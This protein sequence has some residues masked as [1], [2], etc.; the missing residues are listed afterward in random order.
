MRVIIAVKSFRNA[1]LRLSHILDS[2]QRYELSKLMLTDMLKVLKDSETVSAVTL[3]SSEPATEALCRE[4]GIEL[5]QTNED[6]GYSEDATQ[7]IAKVQENS[8]ELI[9][10]LPADLPHITTAD[11]EEMRQSYKEGLVL[12]PAEFDGGT[13]ALI[14]TP[15]LPLELC[16]G[17]DSCKRFRQ[18]AISAKVPFTVV[19]NQ[20]VARD[21][22]RLEDLL[23]LRELH[24]ESDTGSYLKNLSL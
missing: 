24:S 22:D 2:G 12:Y 3:I 19:R 6:S 7:A 16:F 1:K 18:S 14:F 13:N 10:I 15:P 21:M 20:G 5:I 17:T 11:I 4:F 23:W 8:N 9:A